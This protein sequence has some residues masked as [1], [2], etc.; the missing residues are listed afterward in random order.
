MSKTRKVLVVCLV[1]AVVSAIVGIIS[2]IV[3]PEVISM[4][5]AAGPG[6]I[7]VVLIIAL[8]SSKNDDSK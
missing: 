7:A 4:F 6:V 1:I 5:A 8:I 3:N 2:A